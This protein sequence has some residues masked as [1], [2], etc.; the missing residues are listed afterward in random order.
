[1]A[2]HGPV[3]QKAPAPPSLSAVPLPSGIKD[4]TAGD[5]GPTA[6]PSSRD[7]TDHTSRRCGTAPA[8]MAEPDGKDL[9]PL[10]SL[11]GSD[12]P[13]VGWQTAFRDRRGV[14]PF[15]SDPA[16]GVL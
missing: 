8:K 11:M 5:S 3:K 14:T 12:Q 2:T 15:I 4:I 16:C 7:P 9:Q 1:M 10:I 13:E 6:P